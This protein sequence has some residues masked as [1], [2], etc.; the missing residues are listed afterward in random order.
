MLK[1]IL[2]SVF[3]FLFLFFF[4]QAGL[5]FVEFVERPAPGLAASSLGVCSKLVAFV[6]VFVGR[7]ERGE[8]RLEWGT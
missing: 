3:F 6:F 2:F 4:K 7:W 8:R 5:R 1:K